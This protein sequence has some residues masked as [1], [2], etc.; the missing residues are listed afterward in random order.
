MV[1]RAEAT[2]EM[3]DHNDTDA[4]AGYRTLAACWGEPTDDL[5]TAVN[6][7]HLSDV[8]ETTTTVTLQ[9]L[10]REFTRLFVGPG[11]HPCPPY[12]SVYRDADADQSLGP[13]MGE[14]TRDVERWYR[15]YGIG[16]D[17]SNSELPDHV[18]TELEFIGYLEQTEDPA[19]AEKF[20]EEHLSQWI[21]EFLNRVETATELPYYRDLVTI[22]RVAITG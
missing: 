20:R 10:E 17:E 3:S 13:V 21:D 9:A 12:E 6:D 19:T 14:S 16:L 4:G 7:G 2:T 22:T 1:G 15:E 18:T 5:V 8:F 11:E